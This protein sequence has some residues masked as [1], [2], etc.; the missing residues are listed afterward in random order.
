MSRIRL[1]ILC[2]IAAAVVAA[3]LTAPASIAAEP[4]SF[5]RDVAPILK[6]NCYACHDAKKRSGKLEMTSYATL[7]K[8]GAHDDPVVPGKPD[9]SELYNVLVH[10]GTRLMP[11]KDKGG[12]LAARQIAT[13]RKWIDEGG[14]LDDGLDPNADLLRE[15]RARWVSPQP[16]KAYPRPVPVTALSFTPDGS[17]LVAGGHFELTVWDAATGKLLSRVRTRSERAYGFAFLPSGLLA[18]AGGRPGQEGDLCV[19]DLNAAGSA[20]DGVN[21]GKVRVA[22]LIE[23]DDSVLCVAVSGDGKKLAAGG[24]DRAARVW[25]ISAGPAKAKL[26]RTVEVHADWVLGVAFTADGQSLLT[27]SRDKTA[28]VF[29]LAKNEPVK[30][31]P[32]HQATVFAI[33]PRPDG[34][35]AVT[36]G[37]DKTLR[38]W[39]LAADG[40]QIKAIGGHL[41][42]IQRIAVTPKQI[43]TASVDKTVRVWRDDG[44]AVRT[45]TGLADAAYALAVSPDG[46]RVA[47]GAHDGE[48]RVWKLADGAAVTSFVAAPGY[49]PKTAAK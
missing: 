39:P 38:L 1:C 5:I 33:A 13:V 9:D 6:D 29:D 7:R 36:V 45:L 18:V 20:A 4:V 37:G 3:T 49:A 35:S 17:R 40:K 15:L 28:K 10:D 34:K 44:A 16:P 23:A 22:K 19:Y 41:D 26:T 43:V 14:K 25:D 31:F 32:D 2:A 21:D 46:T 11:P 12:P 24:C 27:A 30:S 48:V 47:A 42:E 8:G